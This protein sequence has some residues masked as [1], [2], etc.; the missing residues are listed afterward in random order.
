MSLLSLCCLSS[1]GE[2]SS[3]SWIGWIWVTVGMAFQRS[4]L[5]ISCSLLRRFW[6]LLGGWPVRFWSLLRLRWMVGS[7]RGALY[8]CDLLL[9]HRLVSCEL[10]SNLIHISKEVQCLQVVFKDSLQSSSCTTVLMDVI[11][12][13][14]LLH[15]GGQ[16]N[17]LGFCF[18]SWT[19]VLSPEP[20]GLFGGGGAAAPVLQTLLPL[21]G[22]CSGVNVGWSDSIWQIP[23]SN[24]WCP[25]TST[26]KAFT[27]KQWVILFKRLKLLMLNRP[28]KLMHFK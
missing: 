23:R 7:G 10:K 17:V 3:W 2:L 14:L 6:T 19:C 4:W 5:I 11:L 20:W 16:L 12:L 25:G 18:P 27:R 21:L 9:G 1:S 24:E 13:Y 15:F 26:L 8:R 22:T 28:M